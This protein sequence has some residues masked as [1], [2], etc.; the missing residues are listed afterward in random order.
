MI[1]N[2]VIT[3]NALKQLLEIPKNISSKIIAKIEGLVENPYPYDSKK[4]KI[5]DAYRI[6]V[7]N[8]RI[9]YTILKEVLQIEIIR[10]KHRKDV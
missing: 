2:L 7:G 3:E 1:Y 10:I 5:I 8:Y 9:I 6:R 4:L